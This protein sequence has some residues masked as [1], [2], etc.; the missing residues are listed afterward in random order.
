ME[1]LTQQKFTV[2]ARLLEL[3]HEESMQADCAQHCRN[4]VQQGWLSS[5][6]HIHHDDGGCQTTHV[7]SKS[8]APHSMSEGWSPVQKPERMDSCSEVFYDMKSDTDSRI[9]SSRTFAILMWV[10]IPVKELAPGILLGIISQH[11]GHKDAWDHNVSQ[12]QHGEGCLGLCQIQYPWEQQFDGCVK[13]FCHCDLQ[14][15]MESKFLARSATPLILSPPRY[16]ISLILVI[17]L[18]TAGNHIGPTMTGVQK[19]QKMS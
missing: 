14:L 18:E 16:S 4:N 5:L 12:P 19:T 7:A 3:A 1:M 17:M 15:N 6:K 9:W 11:D 10:E 8:T 2:G 13:G